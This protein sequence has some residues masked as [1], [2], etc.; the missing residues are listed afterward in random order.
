MATPRVFISS[1][2]YDLRQ[3]RDDLERMIRDLGYE[4]VR[5]E[6]GSI[7][8]F[9]REHPELAAYREIELCDI[10][11]SIIGGRFGTESR[12]DSR[13]S[14]SQNELRRAL[15][16]GVQVFIFIDKNVLGEYQT[17]L[18]NRQLSTVQYVHV[19]ETRIFE[20]IEEIHSLPRNNPIA[21]FET[22]GE[23]SNYLRAQW[24]G[25]FQRFLQ[26]QTRIE[27]LQVLAEMNSTARTLKEVV[28]YL[29]Q[30]RMSRDEAI[31]AILQMNHPLF[32]RLAHLTRTEYRVFFTNRVEMGI[33]LGARGWSRQS[34]SSILDVDSIE[35][36]FNEKVGG[37]IKFT[38]ILFD[39][40]DNLII[41]TKEEWDDNW[42]QFIVNA[43]L[44]AQEEDDIPF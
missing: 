4:P 37:Y 24:A 13:F 36:W 42:V 32:A 25:L 18:R 30:E 14:I 2:Y 34:D 27:Q 8:Y 20:F 12:D 31:K 15:E 19:D 7:P 9:K 33:W 29:T 38:K 23:I 5:N 16:R 22:A 35:E 43:R 28:D 3:V 26:E 40:S 17:Y 10:L 44:Q 39:S 6:T 11:V 41:F 1:T 21:S